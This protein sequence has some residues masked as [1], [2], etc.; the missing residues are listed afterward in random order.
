MMKGT[1]RI[2]AATAVLA[3]GV[4]TAE[5]A[6]NPANTHEIRV[7]NDHTASVEVY[8]EDASGRLHNLGRVDNAEF[9]VLSVDAEIA[10]L[11][12]FRLKIYPQAA[13]GALTGATDGIASVDLWLAD[14]DAVNVH[15]GGELTQSQIEVTQG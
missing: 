10:A 4:N 7:I 5:A 6:T 3:F 9:R 1:F 12:E 13:P 8:L 11:G 15:L 2:L 14:G